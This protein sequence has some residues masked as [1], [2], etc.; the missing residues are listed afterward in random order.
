MPRAYPLSAA[1]LHVDG[2]LTFPTNNSPV[3]RPHR[4]ASNLIRS[5][6]IGS[7]ISD[8]DHLWD[9]LSA[10]AQ[11]NSTC[12]TATAHGKERWSAVNN[13]GNGAVPRTSFFDP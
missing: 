8:D 5:D 13:N 1:R 7:G 3:E 11:Y 6:L 9:Y 10:S 4:T 12:T 2:T